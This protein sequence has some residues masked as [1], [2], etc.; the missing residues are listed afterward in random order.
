[1]SIKFN[2]NLN[3][4]DCP[5][6]RSKPD[7]KISDMG[8][9]HDG[10][11]G[12]FSFSLSCPKCKMLESSGYTGKSEEEISIAVVRVCGSWNSKVKEVKSFMHE[13]PTLRSISE[14]SKN[15]K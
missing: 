6:C 8:N 2:L 9:Q 13:E 12:T 14:D 1:M 10:Y 4:L 11:P 7:I 15:E 5:I 3:L